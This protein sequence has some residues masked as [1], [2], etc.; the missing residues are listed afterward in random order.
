MPVTILVLEVSN[1]EYMDTLRKKRYTQ[2]AQ[3]RPDQGLVDLM[4]D[5][6]R[7]PFGDQLLPNRHADHA[8]TTLGSRYVDNTYSEAYGT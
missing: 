7:N 1:T 3:S 5:L 2:A 8:F 4:G 6:A